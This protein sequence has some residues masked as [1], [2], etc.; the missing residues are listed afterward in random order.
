MHLSD[1]APFR[2]IAFRP[3]IIGA[4]KIG[5]VGIRFSIWHGREGDDIFQHAARVYFQHPRQELVPERLVA[6]WFYN[7]DTVGRII[8]QCHP[9]TVR[10]RAL[11][12]LAVGSRDLRFQE[13]QHAGSRYAFLYIGIY[14][15]AVFPDNFIEFDAIQR[16]VINTVRLPACDVRNSRFSHQVPFVRGVYE[17]FCMIAVTVLHAY[18]KNGGVF[19]LYPVF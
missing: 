1:L 10:L 16:F 4:N 7:G 18:G 5:L 11:I 12:A 17:Y 9:V 6:G 15:D 2:I 3:P 14:R 8:G 19:F 13:R